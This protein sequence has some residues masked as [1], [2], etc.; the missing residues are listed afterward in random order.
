MKTESIWDNFTNLYSLS[1]T[2]RFELKPVGSDGKVLSEEQ[3]TAMFKT[4]LEDDRKI[5]EAYIAL[6]PV[7]DKIHENVINDSLESKEAKSIDFTAYFEEYQK[8]KER[9]IEPIEKALRE[10][11]GQTFEDTAT[12][13]AK[14]AGKTEEGK[15]EKPILKE[16]GIKCLTEAGI[17]KYLEKNVGKYVPTEQTKEFIDKE[18]ITNSKGK[19]QIKRTGHL[20]TFDGFF[21]FLEGYN[22]NRKNYYEFKKEASTAVATRIVHENLPKF[23]DNAIQ[24][25]NDKDFVDKKTKEAKT[26]PSRKTEYL[27]AYQYLKKNDRTTQIKDVETNTMIEALPIKEK[28]FNIDFFTKCL[29]QSGIDEY[30]RI[31]GHYNSL[32]NLYNQ[33]RKEIDKDFRRLPPFKIL[34]KQIGS[35]KKNNLFLSLKYDTEEEQKKNDNSSEILSLHGTLALIKQGGEKYFKKNSNSKEEVTIFSIIE[36]LQDQEDWEGVYWSKAAI[37]KISNNYLANWHDIKDRIQ[38]IFKVGSK[39]EKEELKSLASFDN[40]KE[41]PLQIN[42]AVELS[43]LFR[44][45]D[46]NLEVG[47]SEQ[48]FKATI[49]EEK[50]SLIDERQPASRNLINLI[51]ADM[52]DLAENFLKQSNS[53]LQITEYK[54]ETKIKEIKDWLDT[55]KSLLW[56]LKY[57]QVKQSKVKGNY[58]NSELEHLMNLVLNAVD[59]NWFDWYDAVRNYLTKKPQDDA[60]KNKLKLNFEYGNLLNGFVDS[61]S[62]SDNATQYGGYLFRK[63][64][65]FQKN[66]E[67]EYFLGI[68][69]NSKLFRCH[70]K[71]SISKTDK[72]EFE[73]LEY[74]Q[75]KSTTYFDSE[76]SKNKEKL[77]S[78]IEES[79]SNLVREDNKL[80]E[81][82]DQIKKRNKD[83]DITPTALFERIKKYKEFQSILN[84]KPIQSLVKKSIQDLKLSCENFKQRAPKLRDIQNTE[85]IG[86]DGF[87]KIIEDLQSVAKENKVFSFF[88]VSNAEFKSSFIDNKR[89]I[90]LFK[91]SNK[92]LSYSQTSQKDENGEQKRR[93]KGTENLH[94]QFFRALVRE[95]SETTT[96]DLGKGE[97]FFRPLA[98]E[99]KQIHINL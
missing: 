10:K 12:D 55:A 42:D 73:R 28:I 11:I 45:L 46:Q 9:N 37:T 67:F 18:E 21:T 62:D 17:L 7:L 57:F 29:T 53:I 2:L 40:S 89:P 56:I 54:N 81:Y 86:I 49:L 61:Y 70:L 48:F 41:E 16:K 20:E 47:W 94:T 25:S 80:K 91:L 75:A 93:F 71:D 85:Y 39:D 23:C 88:Q 24:F 4:I 58:I 43:G 35:S 33:A 32:I 31:L 38:S 97:I 79:I 15:K 76:Y 96:I 82:S 60:K 77:I 63:R 69:K 26:I 83:G 8:G 65:G 6:K 44:I 3:S 5:K 92:D 30:N 27:N 74:Y 99:K 78:I 13:F 22:H 66:D 1:K 19:K 84:S 64:L 52:K 87:K 95:Y 51:C 68:S 98:I 90:Y 34:F 14:K 50:K 72:S 59:T 36:W